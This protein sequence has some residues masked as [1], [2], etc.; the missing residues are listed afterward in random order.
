M[1]KLLLTISVVVVGM[2]LFSHSACGIFYYEI[3]GNWTLT[4]NVDG[5]TEEIVV[6]FVGGRKGGDVHWNNFYMGAY[7]Y[8]KSLLTFSMTFGSNI[9]YNKAG[10]ENYIGAFDDKDLTSGSFSAIYTDGS[11]TGTWTAVR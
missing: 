6:S 8:E 9:G 1:K 3:S 5:V 11:V 10:T 7:R 4:K 2:G